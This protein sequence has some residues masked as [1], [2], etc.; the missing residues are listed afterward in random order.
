[1]I[2]LNELN[3][4]KYIYEN[5]ILDDKPSYTI[6]LLC[7]YFIQVLKLSEIETVVEID[8][9][10]KDT[11]PNYIDSEWYTVILK[12]IKNANKYPLLTIES[13]N[14][15]KDELKTIQNLNNETYEKLAFAI[16]CL[17]KYQHLRNNSEEYWTDKNCSIS[18][19]KK[20]A[21]LSLNK[22]KMIDALYNLCSTGV[23]R[24]G[25]RSSNYHCNFVSEDSDV[26]V[27]ISD[28][29]IG[30]VD[31]GNQYLNYL[32][33]GYFCEKCGKFTKKQKSKRLTKTTERNKKYCNSCSKYMRKVI[34]TI[35]CIDCGIEVIVQPNNK[36]TI[37]C[38]AC[39]K[40]NRKKQK[41]D[42]YKQRNNI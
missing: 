27:K 26:V 41:H 42:Y 39:Q 34:K 4:A 1:M 23:I 18:Q 21:N 38:E 35:N 24:I 33:K 3:Y 15:T 7:K 11:Y 5:K 14:I 30:M 16:L 32:N 31:L 40:L 37:R 6:S 22:E 28:E 8:K 12:N 2:I 20:Y 36:R 19:L 13:I 29:E 17:S 10:M 9:F 25:F